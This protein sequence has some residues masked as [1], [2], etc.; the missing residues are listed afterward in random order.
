MNTKPVKPTKSDLNSRHRFVL[1]IAVAVLIGCGTMLGS[2]CADSNAAR[3]P[4]P[5][6]EKEPAANSN[7]TTINHTP[8]ALVESN[9]P[10]EVQEETKQEPESGVLGT[11][12]KL[13]EK[14]KSKSGSTAAGASKW[15]QDKLSGAASA[16]NE[17]ADDTWE[18]ANDTFES[19]KSKGLTT[20][21][22]TSEWLG[23]DWNNMESWEYK[24]V[25]L[26]GTDEKLA[27]KLN[28]FGKQGWECFHTEPK[29][30]G[31]RFYL[32]KPTFSYLRQ[33]PFKDV[34]KLVPMMNNGEK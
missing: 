15:V 3:P 16:G 2:G 21:T 23:Q 22:S 27:E 8:T 6:A 11:A 32:K 30:E 28:A 29:T 4:T 24:V 1:A 13:L 34:I 17:T 5:P 20:A 18:W 31:T 33:L 10:Q 26:G 12:G 7:L 14:A 25:T 19:L 9:D